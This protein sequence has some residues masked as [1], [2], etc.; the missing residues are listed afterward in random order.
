MYD[1]AIIGGG[2]VGCAIARELSKY[3][4]S[5]VLIE[6]EAEVGFGTTKTNS[7]IIHAGHHSSLESLKGQ[8]VV[9]GNEMFDELQKELGFGF[10]R[11]GEIVVARDEEDLKTLDELKELGEKKGVKGLELWD[12]DRLRREEP[13]LS[14]SL[15]GALY[16]PT[17]GVINPY[18]FA[19]SLIECAQNNGIELLVENPV[20]SITS[21]DDGLVISTSQKKIKASFVLNCAGVFADDMAGLLGLS[22][23]TIHP[24]KGEEYMLDKGL[25]GIVKHLIFPVPKGVSKGTLII[26]TYDGT[27]MVGP[28][29]DEVEDKY[30]VST[31]EEGAKK[32][33]DFVSSMC[34]SIH[35]RSTIAEFAGL[36]AASNTGDFIIGTTDV[37]GFINVAGIQSPG[38]TASPAI[39][40]YV[41]NILGKQGL[42]L[43]QKDEWDPYVT[44]PPRFA[45]LSPEERSQCCKENKDFGNVVCRCELVTEAE[46]Q[47]AI[48]HG[49]RTLDGVKF[50]TRAGMGRCQGGFC[51][52]RIMEALAED[53]G[54]EFYEITKRGKAS[55][56]VCPEGKED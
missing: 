15:T 55:W 42:E 9:K 3:Q 6:K 34:P 41:L 24:R 47:T 32:V 16:A 45:Q 33:F 7:G 11:C 27:I 10:R 53:Q 28:T 46:I 49:A 22:D 25:E 40:L 20:Q 30:N 37:N 5:T 50:R 8:L 2:V 48:S 44:P 54:K 29:A 39:A 19:F 17:A 31:T 18:E 43:I 23:F 21:T 13:N 56:I 51:S 26:P 38:L 1:V 12:T 4:L 14:I 35:P 52:S 36:R